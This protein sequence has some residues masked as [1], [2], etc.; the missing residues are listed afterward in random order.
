MI[1]ATNHGPAAA[2][3]PLNVDF[4]VVLMALGDLEVRGTFNK[5]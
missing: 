4:G 5:N 2:A 3:K 1:L